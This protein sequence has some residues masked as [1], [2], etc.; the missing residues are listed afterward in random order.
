MTTATA[1]RANGVIPLVPHMPWTVGRAPPLAII[2][3]PP[4][5][6]A[7]EKLVLIQWP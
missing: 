1:R 6:P 5:G 4:P 2:R 3:N 7:V